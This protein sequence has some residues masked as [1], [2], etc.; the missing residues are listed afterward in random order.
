MPSVCRGLCTPFKLV[1]RPH[2]PFISCGSSS[3]QSCLLLAVSAWCWVNPA[4]AFKQTCILRNAHLSWHISVSTYFKH[5][6]FLLLYF[7]FQ[8]IYLVSCPSI[9]VRR[10]SVSAFPAQ[11]KFYWGH[12]VTPFRLFFFLL[13]TQQRLT[14]I[15]II[16]GFNEVVKKTCLVDAFTTL[17]RNIS[18]VS[19][20]K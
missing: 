13:R 16:K 3:F 5:P 4:E 17:N 20:A 11:D 1:P 18:S 15:C 19:G 8:Y 14:G 6:P 10:L 12:M 7:I 9:F 2:P